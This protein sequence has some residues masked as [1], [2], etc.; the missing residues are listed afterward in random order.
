M[1]RNFTATVKEGQVGDPCR[2]YFETSED[3]GDGDRTFVL[4]LQPGT[5][6]N[7]AREVAK[8]L[9]AKVREVRLQK[10]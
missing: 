2:V 9:N 7:D 6:I 5:D 4:T 1:A 10:Y 8:L 3:I